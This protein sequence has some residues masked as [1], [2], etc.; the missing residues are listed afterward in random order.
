MYKIAFLLSAC[1]IGLRAFAFPSE[2]TRA[3]YIDMWKEEAIYQMAT[4]G[5]P[6]SITL[7]QGILESRDGNSRLAKEGNNHFGIKCHS[8]WEGK[9]IYE[10]DETRNECFRHYKNARESFDDH[11]LFLKK[12]RY[13]SLFELNPDDYKGWAKGLRECGYATNPDYAKLLIRIIEENNLTQYDETGLSYAKSNT[14][15]DR[16]E[17]TPEAPVLS[18]NRSGRKPRVA[19]DK[20]ER[21]EITIA[22]NHEVKVSENNIKYVVVK[23]G[24]TKESIAQDIDLNVWILN[25][26]N[27]FSVNT[28]LQPGDIVYLQPKR[29]KASVADYTVQSGDTWFSISQKFGIKLKQLRKIN[30]AAATGDPTPGVSLKLKKA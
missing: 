22:H 15:P 3:Q 20:E 21:S 10:D 23:E 2:N 12:P 18:K 19:V 6:A 24:E 27:D 29:N 30:A 17:T 26:F 1:L 7:A 14:V 16:K 5:V 25:K 11:S 13:A 8:D 28:Q 4:H 9:R